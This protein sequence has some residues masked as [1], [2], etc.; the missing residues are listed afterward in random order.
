MIYFSS[1]SSS[2]LISCFI[3]CSS[4]FFSLSVFV[5]TEWWNVYQPV[6]ILHR[7]NDRRFYVNLRLLRFTMHEFYL[8]ALH[9]NEVNY[10][11]V[12]M[13]A[14]GVQWEPFDKIIMIAALGQMRQQTHSFHS[15]VIRSICLYAKVFKFQHTTTIAHMS[16]SKDHFFSNCIYDTIHSHT[17]DVLICLRKLAE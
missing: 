4:F 10:N 2:R 15:F 17:D 6:I 8:I 3:S 1:S 13:G 7:P 11:V 12:W 14:D 5:P 16:M 9:I